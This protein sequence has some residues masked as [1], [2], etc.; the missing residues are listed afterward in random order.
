MAK[1][2]GAAGNRDTTITKVCATCGKQFHPRRSGYEM[3]AK[4]CSAACAK[5]AR[6]KGFLRTRF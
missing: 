5:V 2:A 1:R 3:I 6:K 4:Y